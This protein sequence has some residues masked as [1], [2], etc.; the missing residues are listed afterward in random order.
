MN[1]KEEIMLK[2]IKRKG[3]SPLKPLKLAKQVATEKASDQVVEEEPE[4][5]AQEKAK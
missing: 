3:P 1:Y 2:P 5:Q 4:K